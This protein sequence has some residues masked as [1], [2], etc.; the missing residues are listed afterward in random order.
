MA[1]QLQIRRGTSSQVAAF[2]GAE[3]EIVVNTTNDSVHVNDG[4]TAGGFEL[5]R[6]DLNNVSDTSLNAALT[7]NTVSALTITT[8]TLGSTAITATGAEINIL[9]GVTATAAE[10]NILDGVTST[11]AELNILDGVTATTAELNYVDGVTSAIQTQLD[12]KAPLA[13]PTF[14]GTVTVPGLTTTADV[15]FADNDKAIF[16]AGSDLQIYHDGS[17]SFIKDAGTG[18]LFVQGS[19]GVRVLGADTS[20]NLARFNENDSVQLYYNNAEKLA[21]TSTGIDVAGSLVS[22]KNATDPTVR[23]ENTDASL[24]TNQ[25]IGDID[26]YQSDPSGG[27]AGVVSKIRSVNLSSFQGD[28]A[29]AFHTGTTSTLTERV[30]ITST[31]VG[32]GTSSPGVALDVNGGSTTQLRLTAADSTSAS[33]VNFGDQANVAVGR[34]IYSHV[35]DSFSFKTNNVNDR[36]VIDAGGSVLI[37]KSTPTDLHNTWNHLII[38]E[39]GA[40]ISENGAGGIDGISISDNAYV[41]ADTGAYAYQ[42]TGAASIIRQTAGITQFANAVSGSA[43]AGLTFSETARIDSSGAL[44]VGTN[45]TSLGGSAVVAAGVE[46]DNTSGQQT[47]TVYNSSTS[48]GANGIFLVA[49]A[50][51]ANT[52]FDIFNCWTNAVTDK[53]F[54]V[55]GD[56]NVFCDGSFTGGGADYAEF[57]EWLDGN[58]SSEDRRGYS[59]ILESGKIR[60]ATFEDD[61]SQI[62]GVISANPAMIGD[63]D[64]ERWKGKY[65]RDDFGAYALDENGD[66]QLNPDYDETQTYVS[67]ENR[68]EWDIV[69]LMGKLRIRKGQPTGSN[70]IKIKDINAGIEEWLVR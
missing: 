12:A 55:R 4:S 9:D 37:G 3:G 25:T 59:V 40:I 39:K 62:I 38:G 2:T 61:A 31:G 41:D 5:A 18:I 11:A 8:L 14:T 45:S 69:G 54:K 7:G 32:I 42:T 63:G 22:V 1:T 26:F 64:L 23:I 58:S 50:R 34:I 6:A 24:T 53:E 33:I 29:L 35:N 16:G 20:E 46:S 47:M 51:T 10:L 19:G 66:K 36:L 28:G 15:S 27:G 65:L 56:G 44:L 43:G 48:C 21:T 68:V 57:F 70:W 60:K 52:A 17:N 13:S 30:R 67:R 49:T